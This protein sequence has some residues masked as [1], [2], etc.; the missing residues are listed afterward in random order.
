MSLKEQI[1]ADVK[2]AMKNK[3]SDK[4]LTLRFI[5]SAIKNCEI[6]IRPKEISD[7]EVQ[8]VLKK[9]AKQRRDSI[10]QYEKAQRQ[11]LASKEKLELQIIE[12]YLPES[13]SPEKIEELVLEAIRET[14]ASSMKD[15]GKV[16]KL[17]LEKSQGAA[18]NKIVSDIVK[19]KL[20]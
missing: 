20:Q 6:E 17:V 8:T 5:H 16:M 3:E 18:D 19:S 9:L 2:S 7:D 1:M 14:S 11:D 4:L 12:S 10:E 15:M 13:L